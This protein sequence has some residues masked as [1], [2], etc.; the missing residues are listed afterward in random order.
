MSRAILFSAMASLTVGCVSNVPTDAFSY[1]FPDNVQEDLAPIVAAQPA[2]AAD[3]ITNAIG[4]PLA[5]VTTHPTEATEEG[6]ATQAELACLNLVSG[7]VLWRK[8]FEAMTRPE[9][10]GDVVVTS[11]RGSVVVL[12]LRSGDELWREELDDLAYVGASRSGN[13]LVWVASVG[14]AGGANR[15]GRLAA[16]DARSGRE[17]WEHRIEGVLGHP[18]LRGGYIFVPWDRQNIAILKLQDGIEVAR[19]RTTDDVIGWVRAEP[20]GVFYGYRGIYKFNERSASGTKE[21]STYRL[22]PLAEAP[23]EPLVQD[24]GYYPTPGTRSARGRIRV[25]YE[26][27]P[28]TD[29]ETIPVEGDRFYFV[30]FRYV[31]AFDGEENLSWARVLPRDIV[32]AHALTN[33]VLTI[34]EDGNA[35]LLGHDDGKTVWEQ[36]YDLEL[37]SAG[38]DV[39]DFSPPSNVEANPAD[40]A[41]TLRS[42]LAEI[43]GDPDN[44]LVP[45]R[46]YAV[47]LLAKME[48]PEITRDLLDLYAQR[49]TPGAL[50]EA[51]GN[52]LR[53]REVGTEFLVAA[54]EQHYDYLEDT[55]APPLGLIVPALLEQRVDGAVEGLVAHMM[56]HETPRAELAT[57]IRGVVELGDENVVPPLTTFLTLYHAD[58]LFQENGDALAVAAEGLFRHGGEEG[59]EV[60]QALMAQ[61][62]TR[63][64]TQ[65]AIQ[66]LFDREQADAAAAARAEAEA[67][68]AA[69][70]EAAR[71]EAAARPVK[72]SQAQIN[73]VFVAHTEH[74]RG[75]IEGE[76]ERNPRLGQVRFAFIINSDG[77]SEEMRYAPTSDPMIECLRPVVEELR[78][79][80]FRQ[81]R[82]RASFTVSLRGGGSDQAEEEVVMGPWWQ[83]AQQRSEA[84]GGERHIGRPW[85]QIRRAQAPAGGGQGDGGQGD[86][87]QDGQGDGGGQDGQG[88]GGEGG[89]GGFG[90]GQG[91]GGDGG[92][93]QPWWLPSE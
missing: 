56:D 18:Q 3:S 11:I 60:L 43:A 24:D 35:R 26:P 52:A 39:G 28:S 88:D 69:A 7:E 29:T 23:R 30:Y 31:F 6:P 40:E 33:G 9:I 41:R 71:A 78:F 13:T 80:Q 70:A 8:P 77:T 75:C 67:A 85:W 76:L 12:D 55:P 61:P 36:D 79:P 34:A 57:V 66:G 83:R 62:R 91:D 64:P 47:E 14:V 72:L 90:D 17:L 84:A 4:E 19:L 10:L 49:S 45:A 92:G 15:K 82:Q 1:Q 63:E 37:A 32:R 93:D 20:Q 46:A 54:L 22:A 73:E 5:V 51:I 50:R 65:L 27:E 86:D 48:E 74:L 81:R 68:E 53:V 42:S 25:Y 59:R 87:G 21:G 38:L 44:R 58:S 16:V 2:P 89:D